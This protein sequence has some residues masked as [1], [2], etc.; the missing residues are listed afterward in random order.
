MRH[1]HF[2]MVSGYGGA[3][4]LDAPVYSRLRCTD[5]T[6]GG[7]R[8]APTTPRD[9]VAQPVVK[10]PASAGG[11]ASAQRTPRASWAPVFLAGRNKRGQLRRAV[12][13]WVNAAIDAWRVAV[14]SAM[15]RG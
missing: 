2:R 7:S 14:G 12:R 6:K 4:P 10:P 8:T 13:N 5:K 9:V 11:S 3:V 1:V 15:G